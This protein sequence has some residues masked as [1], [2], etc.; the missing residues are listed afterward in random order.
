ME[1]KEIHNKKIVRKSMKMAT[2]KPIEGNDD[3]IFTNY[4]F[5]L[6]AC[7]KPGSGKTTIIMSQ[8][9]NTHGIFYRKFNKVYIFSPS[10]ATIGK[11]IELEEDR[12]IPEFDVGKL[13][14]IIQ[15][16]SEENSEEK[17]VDLLGK[18]PRVRREPDEVLLIFD[19]LI[20]D[21][22]KDKS[23][24]FQRAILNRRHLHLSVICVSQTYNMVPAKLRKNFSDVLILNT[25]NQAELNCIR[26]ELTSYSTKE[27]NDLIDYAFKAKH[28]FLLFRIGETFRNFNKLEIQKPKSKSKVII[29]NESSTSE[30]E[31]EQSENNTHSK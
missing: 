20:S 21:I 12:F 17:E 7:G 31:S 8:L 29:S 5:S 2:D 18:S 15:A 24:A 22:S 28:D 19:D 16:Q 26:K 23:K 3:K 11:K 9:T 13:E 1:I 30:S 10:V 4:G 27:F 6:L 25:N 14:E